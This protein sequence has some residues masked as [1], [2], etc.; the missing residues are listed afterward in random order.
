MGVK[1]VLDHGLH[2]WQLGENISDV[3]IT[4]LKNK[5]CAE[6]FHCERL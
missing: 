4:M 6:A 5:P 2:L 3:L 1:N